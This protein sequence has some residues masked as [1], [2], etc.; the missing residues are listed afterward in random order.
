MNAFIEGSF[1][2]SLLLGMLAAVNPCGFVLLPTYLIAYLSVTDDATV[3]VRLRRSIVVG[4]SVAS[5]FLVVF[6]VV[7]IVSRIFTNWIE[8][9]AKYPALVIGIALI[10]M[11]VRMVFGWRPKLW[12][13]SLSG[14]SRRDSFVGMFGFGVVYAIASIGCT[15]GLLTTA[16]MG[17]FSRDGVVSGVLSVA[18]YGLG[19]GV[20]VVALTTTLAFAKTALV[21]G[22]RGIM[23][24]I[25]RV[26]SMLV[27]ATG[28][29]LT[30]YW[31]IAITA[32]TGSDPL[33]STLGNW[34]T[35]IV[36]RIAD[37]GAVPLLVIFVLVITTALV[38]VVQQRKASDNIKQSS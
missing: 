3:G 29:Y 27:L 30:W 24:T 22:G 20:F 18:L 5:G 1:A 31:Y 23:Q 14:A 36:S 10:I 38:I 13:P 28:V 34:Q 32:R 15:I 37:I 21:R 25:D 2:Y 6:V 33:L 9:N 26:S 19:M 16:V 8:A 17:S 12:A 35:G 11:G 7:G 4:T